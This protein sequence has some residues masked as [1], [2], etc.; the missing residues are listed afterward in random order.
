MVRRPPTFN[1]LASDWASSGGN[2]L[3]LNWG[4][5]NQV[6]QRR[7][8]A[9]V[10]AI[11]LLSAMPRL[12][13]GSVLAHECCHAFVRLGDFPRLELWVEEGLCQLMA[14]LWLEELVSRMARA[15][16]P[17][18]ASPIAAQPYSCWTPRQMEGLI[19]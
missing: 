14:L 16:S 10:T 1:S 2:P 3:A 11:I 15:P 4:F 6:L 7:A 9:R 18:S 12:L 8:G 13:C 5:Q 19:P 17:C